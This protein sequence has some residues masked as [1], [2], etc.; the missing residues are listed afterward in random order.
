MARPTKVR[1]RHSSVPVIAAFVA[2]VL[3]GASQAGTLAV[4]PIEQINLKTSTL[5][6]LGQTYRVSPSAVIRSQS[7]AVVTLDALAPNT[8]VAIGGSE[9]SAGKTAVSSITELSQL[10][11]PGATQ[12][13]VTGIVSSEAAT[14]Q[15]RV[16]NLSIDINSALTGDNQNFAVGNLVRISGT[17]P[18]LGGL[19]L[20]QSIAAVNGIAGTGFSSNG[21]AGTGASSNGIAGTGVSVKGIAGTGHFANGIAGTGHSSNGIAGTGSK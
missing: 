16:G 1:V 21:I 3:A 13:I 12:L 2:T 19:F 20:A 14:G 4:G 6:V 11:V 15:I 7:G 17:Q 9:S 18:N 8:L 5:T 10:D